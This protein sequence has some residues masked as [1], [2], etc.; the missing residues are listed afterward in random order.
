MST[1]SVR[2]V[3]TQRKKRHAESLWLNHSV[4]IGSPLTKCQ[5]RFVS[6]SHCSMFVS[7][8]LMPG[9]SQ[10]SVCYNQ[11]NGTGQKDHKCTQTYTES[12]IEKLHTSLEKFSH[13]MTA[14]KYRVLVRT[15]AYGCVSKH[16]QGIKH[17]F[18]L[19]LF[20][21]KWLICGSRQ[22]WLYKT[23]LKCSRQKCFLWL[24]ENLI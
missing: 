9:I 6:V 11:C 5:S 15:C 7:V 12:Q 16:R 17:A 8:V 22:K 19:H 24:N 3:K 23:G 4:I 14:S 18:T 1:K 2:W 10:H 21:N 13:S 20:M